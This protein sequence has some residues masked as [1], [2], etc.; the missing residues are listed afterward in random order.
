[1]TEVDDANLLLTALQFGDGQFPGG[2][3]AFSWGLESLAADGKLTRAGFAR[4][5]AGQLQHRWATSDRVIIAHAHGA[6]GDLPALL[7]IDEMTDALMVV[8]PLR[9]GSRR[10]GAALLGTH[11]RLGTP[12]AR[13]LKDAIDRDEAAGHLAVVQGVTLA[14]VGLDGTAALAV[15]VY[16]MAQSF[17]TAAIRLGLISHL[18]AQRALSG[19]R[20]F[21][22]Q[23]L[24]EPVPSLEDIHSFT[25][26]AEIAAMRHTD[27]TQRLFSN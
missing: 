10:A 6:A 9:T 12:G 23:V 21:L 14:G 19:I 11:L 4:F 15:S 22:A 7:A 27:K 16:G 3:F 26:L 2:G 13:Q 1:M 20:P 24:T 18:D 5:L 17:C 8:E 25:P